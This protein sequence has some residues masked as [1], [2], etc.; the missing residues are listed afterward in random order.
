VIELKAC[1]GSIAAPGQIFRGFSY[2]EAAASVLTNSQL[3]PFGKPG[4]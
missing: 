4:I 2:A 3:D 1:A